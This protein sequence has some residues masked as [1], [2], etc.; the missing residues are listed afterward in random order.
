MTKN[1]QSQSAN[2][3]SDLLHVARRREQL[4]L[5]GLTS[6]ALICI[7]LVIFIPVGW[8]FSL[9]FLSTDGSLSLENYQKMIEY[10]S[11]ARVFQATF[12]VSFFTTIL[13]ILIGYPLAYFLSQLPKKYVGPL[14]R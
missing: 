1:V 12:K 11:Y 3:N 5:I 9:S 8:L 10:K 6:P 13:C 2:L 4:T 14:V 7:F